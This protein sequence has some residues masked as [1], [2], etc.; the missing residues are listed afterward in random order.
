MRVSLGQSNTPMRR[1]SVFRPRI[2]CRLAFFLLCFAVMALHSPFAVALPPLENI[3]E[4]LDRFR[5][6]TGD[7]YG[8]GA[9]TYGI[10]SEAD[11]VLYRTWGSPPR[12]EVAGNTLVADW[13][14]EDLD[15]VLRLL[16]AALSAEDLNAATVAM[17]RTLSPEVHTL[18]LLDSEVVYVIGGPLDLPVVHVVLERDTYRLRRLDMPLP[19][20]VYTVE[21]DDYELAEGWFPS[22]IEV[23]REERVLLRLQLSDLHRGSSP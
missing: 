16:G 19:E 20:G 14:D 21:L 9:L 15:I 10:Y 12:L 8:S 23:R 1:V 13:V 11:V 5:S 6:A 3:F 17:G 18:A 7:V 4:Q 22:T 2:T